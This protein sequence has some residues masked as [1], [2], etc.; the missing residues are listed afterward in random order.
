[1]GRRREQHVLS[2]LHQVGS[3][4]VSLAGMVEWNSGCST[5]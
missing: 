1:M 4:H 3:L 2:S 5:G